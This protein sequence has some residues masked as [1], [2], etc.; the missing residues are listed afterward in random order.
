MHG[1]HQEH[2]VAV[3]P[4]TRARRRVRAWLRLVL[5]RW[6]WPLIGIAVLGVLAVGY[7]GFSRYQPPDGA[8]YPRLTRM[9]LSLQLFFLDGGNVSGP[10]P[11][12]LEMAR[13]AAPALAAL[14]A[15]RTAA[16]VARS[17]LDRSR[18][19]RQRHHVVVAGVSDAGMR[20]SLELAQ[21]GYHVVVVDESVTPAAANELRSAGALVLEADPCRVETLRTARVHRADR[22]VV[23]TPDDGRT[24][25]V[26]AAARELLAGDAPGGVVACVAQLTDPDLCTVLNADE[27]QR[28][29]AARLRVDF[30][31]PQAVGAAALLRRYP[32]RLSECSTVPTVMV[33]GGG[34]VA[35]RVQVALARDSKAVPTDTP[36]CLVGV[37]PEQL[38]ER[39]A[40]S[41]ELSRFA[42]LSASGD[43]G[44]ALAEAGR[45]LVAYVCDQEEQE[46]VRHTIELR[47]ALHGPSRVLVVRP[48]VT[49][50]TRL[51]AHDGTDDGPAI[52]VV[53][54]QDLAWRPELLLY[55]TAE[56]LAQ[57]LHEIYLAHRSADQAGDDGD[58]SLRP[59]DELPDSLRASNRSHAAHIPVK[60]R[61][62]DRILTPATP[63]AVPPFTPQEIECMSVLEHERWVDERWAAGW[64]PGPR[65]PIARTTPYLVPWGELPE[66]VRDKDR[67]FVRQ[68]PELLA[69]VGLQA[70]PLRPAAAGGTATGVPAG[71]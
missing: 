12:Q 28:G 23:F 55:G 5:R 51:L 68:L 36:I 47:R 41:P 70:R 49:P 32:P 2:Q 26:V 4:R 9:Y 61:A 59:W 37:R 44:H 60:L 7:W 57:A 10:L 33:I 31:D 29:A 48:D 53:G 16:A 14:A 42:R 27:L 25:R 52:Q 30:L 8:T 58:L 46:A 1:D 64:R 3:R 43:L 56:L 15:L 35:C 71:Q 54:L 63:A 69:S 13:V 19:R 20:L 40:R 65:D 11:W 34:D 22:V 21:Q 66:E 67:I 6:S 17:Q 38:A 24:V 18:I 39:V 62:V 45:P 50:L